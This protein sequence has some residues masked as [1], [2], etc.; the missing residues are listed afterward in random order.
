MSRRNRACRSCR[1]RESRECYKETAAV[2]F[3]LEGAAMF[4]TS[5]CVCVCVLVQVT[6]VNGTVLRW[7]K[8]RTR[9]VSGLE[10]RSTRPPTPTPP[11]PLSSYVQHLH[12]LSLSL[13]LSSSFMHCVSVL[14]LYF[15]VRLASDLT[16]ILLAPQISASTG[17]LTRLYTYVHQTNAHT[18]AKLSITQRHRFTIAYMNSSFLAPDIFMKF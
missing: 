18:T 13:S 7:F 17:H 5:V 3:Q 2:E 15:V 4:G 6:T 10:R 9:L 14:R 8:W 16:V 11:P 1:T 12:S